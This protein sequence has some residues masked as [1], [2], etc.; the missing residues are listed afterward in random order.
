MEERGKFLLRRLLHF[1]FSLPAFFPITQETGLVLST[2]GLVFNSFF[3]RRVKF[4]RRLMRNEVDPGIL[5][6]PL[7]L[8][9]A[10]TFFPVESARL[11]WVVLGWGDPAGGWA[12]LIEK[13]NRGKSFL[14]GILFFL[15]ALFGGILWML[16]SRNPGIFFPFLLSLLITTVVERITPGDWDN[17]VIVLTFC[18]VFTGI[19]QGK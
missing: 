6:Y 8:L 13:R 3:F 10:F 5:L 14:G 18:A 9:L 2:L 4:L 17:L 19:Q 15:G 12:L 1:L 7:S 11:S 16:V